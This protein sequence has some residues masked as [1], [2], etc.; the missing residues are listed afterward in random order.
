VENL[1]E[2]CPQKGDGK[3]ILR[4]MLANM[5]EDLVRFLLYY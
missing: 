3:A 1:F 2:E 4:W 5:Y